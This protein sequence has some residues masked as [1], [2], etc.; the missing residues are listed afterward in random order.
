[1][2]AVAVAVV[3][4][5][6]GAGTATIYRS[7]H[8][9]EHPPAGARMIAAPPGTHALA[10]APSPS[11]SA[12]APTVADSPPAPP[13][14][15]VVPPV[16]ARGPRASLS[17]PLPR[18]ALSPSELERETHLIQAGDAALRAG[19]AAAALAFFDEH[20]RAFPVGV[21]AEERTA[22]RVLAL[23]AL[24]REVEARDEAARFLRDRPSAP[25]AAE[26]RASCG[27]TNPERR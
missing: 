5:A 16:A 8:A 2:K 14:D 7:A 27:A 24:G 15:P 4:A 1:V 18:E 25:L 3:L 13:V 12:S 19:N 26:V 17:A 22:E 10:P 11:T 20:A 21:L 9:P 6:A 23:C